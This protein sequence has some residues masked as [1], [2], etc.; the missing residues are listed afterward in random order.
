MLCL[1]ISLCNCVLLENFYRFCSDYTEHMKTFEDKYT[2]D[3][4]DKKKEKNNNN[5]NNSF[6]EKSFNGKQKTVP[7]QIRKFAIPEEKSIVALCLSDDVD[8]LLNAR[9]QLNSDR[10]ERKNKLPIV[11]VSSVIP[12]HWQRCAAAPHILLTF[13]LY[14]M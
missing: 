3:S 5:D 2:T 6:S 9:Q 12:L 4:I 7:T 1:P 11:W 8:K 14:F 10:P 13:I